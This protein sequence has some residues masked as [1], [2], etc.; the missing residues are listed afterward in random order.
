MIPNS[1]FE[2][3]YETDQ[4]I[5]I[6]IN[7]TLSE[8]LLPFTV[9]V[10]SARELWQNLERRFGGVS[11]SHIHQLRSTLQSITKGTSS[12]S[13]YFQRLKEVTDALAAAGAPVDD[14][15]LLMIILNGLSDDYDSFVDSVQF[16]LADTTVDDLHGF[17]LS[18]ELAL[19]RK[20]H[21][22][23]SSTEPFQAFQTSSHNAPPL[24]P[25]PSLLPKP[26]AYAAH[27]QNRD[28]RNSF[29]NTRNQRNYNTNNNRNRF[30]RSTS[31]F[32]NRGGSRGGSPFFNNF[33]PS[34]CQICEDP[35]H[36]AIDCSH[37]MNPTFQG[38]VPPAKLA[39]YANPPG[40]SSPPWLL[41]SG[42]SSHMTNNI[43]NLQNPQPYHGSE[44]V[45]IGD[46]QG[47]YY[48]EDAF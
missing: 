47:S 37:R 29:N 18:K 31:N 42:A 25:T 44:K 28:Q 30:N 34:P 23:G 2:L 6:W 17:F 40:H 26:Q 46:G 27:P 1:A 3:W 12:I 43:Q 45:Y 39:M 35:G 41:D 21:A 19:A 24:L 4:N 9:G 7:S 33:K 13:E 22:K 5:I 8:D 15:D 11:R 14:H 10:Q 36:Q 48:G 38:C 20:Q 16:R 32:Q